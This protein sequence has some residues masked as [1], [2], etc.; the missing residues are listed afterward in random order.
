MRSLRPVGA[1][2]VG[3]LVP[4]DAGAI[5]IRHDRD[6]SRYMAAAREL[7]APV[8]IAMA[9]GTLID[10]R[11]ILT[12]AH[13]ADGLSPLTGTVS[14]EG[15][16]YPV[17]RVVLH[18]SWIGDLGPGRAEPQWIDLALI[19]LARPVRDARPVTLYAKPDERGKTVHF[20]GRGQTGTG[21]SG[22]THE[23]RRLRA[24]T[25]VVSE[26]DE[27]HLYFRFDEPPAATDLEGI[28]GPG[29]SGG[30]A[31]IA[32]A[33]GPAVAGVSSWNDDHGPGLCT[34]GTTEVYTRVSTYLP[35]IRRTMQQREGPG[36]VLTL[37]RHGWPDTPAGRSA[38]AFFAAY[39]DGS[40]AALT[41][42]A[43]AWLTPEARRLPGTAPA[44][45]SGSH[46]RT[47]LQRAGSTSGARRKRSG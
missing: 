41:A 10:P 19:R 36:A 25:D 30:P 12:A 8:D 44:R 13:V 24:A 11:W 38:A 9:H 35:W 3:I 5:V 47:G 29:D 23:D 46:S 21:R 26:V 1:L 32:T 27:G 34:Y 6:D 45:S 2:V 42:Y 28:S 15:E 20:V 16:A 40:V 7:P 39:R 31:L 22:P 33:D 18:P 4:A 17:D 43:D 37:D 14:I